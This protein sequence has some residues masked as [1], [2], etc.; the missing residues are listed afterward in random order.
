MAKPWITILFP[1]L[2]GNKFEPS[3]AFENSGAETT[4][5]NGLICGQTQMA[6]NLKSLKSRKL[7][8]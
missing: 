3:K 1:I 6:I 5:I 7:N 8:I 4:L 2:T